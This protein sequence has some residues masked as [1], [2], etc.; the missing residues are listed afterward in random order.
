MYRSYRPYRRDPDPFGYC[1]RCGTPTN[2]S[3]DDHFPECSHGCA[4]WVV[5][6]KGEW[7]DI[8]RERY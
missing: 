1:R 6:S 7:M 5:D 3:V 4:E 2:R 8:E